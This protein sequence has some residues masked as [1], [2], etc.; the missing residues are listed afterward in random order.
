M[1]AGIIDTTGNIRPMSM[2]AASTFAVSAL[3]AAFLFGE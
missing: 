2:P 3:D 1:V